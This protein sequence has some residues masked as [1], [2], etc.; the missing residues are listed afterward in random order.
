MFVLAREATRLPE[1]PKS[2]S[3]TSPLVFTR[4]FVGLTSVISMGQ[5]EKRTERQGL[6]AVR[7]DW[8]SMGKYGG[9]PRWIIFRLSLRYFSPRTVQ[10]VTHA[11]IFSSRI[12]RP[13]GTSLSKLPPSIYYQP[14]LRNEGNVNPCQK[15]GKRGE[16]STY[17][18]QMKTQ[19][20][21]KK[22]P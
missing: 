14:C 15:G 18:M 1:T 4:M 10:L 9:G 22:P 20:S 13:A 17:S 21:A 11:N 8:E 3:L 12:P 19:D 2:Q 16:E 6:C 7:N 5:A